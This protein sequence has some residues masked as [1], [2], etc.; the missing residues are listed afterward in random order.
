MVEDIQQE[1]T[2]GLTSKTGTI[3]STG[4]AHFTE[5][6]TYGTAQGYEFMGKGLDGS[7]EHLQFLDSGV[8][9]SS[10]ADI[11]HKEIAERGKD[12]ARRF[13]LGYVF[14]NNYAR[15]AIYTDDTFKKMA[16]GNKK[17]AQQLKDKTFRILEKEG[18]VGVEGRS[19]FQS[20]DSLQASNIHFVSGLGKDE[21]V[22][23]AHT[24]R[25]QNGDFDSDKFSSLIQKSRARVTYDDGST[26]IMKLDYASYRAISTTRGMNV[27]LLDKKFDES[28]AAMVHNASEITPYAKMQDSSWGTENGAKDDS[29]GTKALKGKGTYDGTHTPN[30]AREYTNAERLQHEN[31]LY[32]L[33]A[34]YDKVHG[35]GAAAGLKDDYAEKMG[36]FIGSYKGDE[37]EKYHE[38]LHYKKW[39]AGWA[40]R[41]T[42]ASS[43]KA[44]GI[45]NKGLYEL[46]R[47]VHDK[48]KLTGEQF[49]LFQIGRMALEEGGLSGKNLRGEQDIERANELRDAFNEV[50]WAMGSD[51]RSKRETAADRIK[52][53]VTD[54]FNSREDKEFSG[55]L[56]TK[57]YGESEE[58]I[59]KTADLFADIVKNTKIS[60]REQQRLRLAVSKSGLRADETLGMSAED[61]AHD[62][63]SQSGKT[64]N[65][66]VRHLGLNRDVV[67]DISNEDP[68]SSALEE[69]G[70][71]KRKRIAEE[72][73]SKQMENRNQRYRHVA[74]EEA[75]DAA[76]GLMPKIR[77][78]ASMFE[79]GNKVAA[80]AVGVAAGLMTAG[81]AAG[82]STK[83]DVPTPSQS[84][85][86]YMSNDQGDQMAM[87][88]TPSLADSN[89]NVMRGGPQ[90]GYVINISA[91]TDHGQQA[92]VD[93]ISNAA[94]GMT[95]QNGSVNVNVSTSLGNSL[96]QLQVNRMVAHAIGVA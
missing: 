90:S 17:L 59:S 5:G 56:D 79:G 60:Q 42:E 86:M 96:S 80:A 74:A 35:D 12:D 9:F 30:Y 50:I 20:L 36:K 3:H 52:T 62:S 64:M 94:S 31:S 25:Q 43:K 85:A 92:A 41:T 4:V 71:E 81:Y 75:V 19:P 77:Q 93:A 53:L 15:D 23:N 2:T 78:I 70:R 22:V 55:R 32:E 37:Y 51:D 28:I 89:L 95:P 67:T 73:A 68:V 13:E 61:A 21:F 7:Y 10:V 26:A 16:G 49:N 91:K 76:S 82:P 87:Q 63:I 69:T 34:A 11:M 45:M 40:E 54:V 46:S 44:A 88:P 38:A 72:Y 65:N 58:Q 6:V 1:V 27:E 83:G 66:I 14:A 18:T 33:E 39:E 57:I 8:T 47:I 24:F 29:L 84:Q 48:A